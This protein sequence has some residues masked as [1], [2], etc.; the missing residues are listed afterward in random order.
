MTSIEE[1][2][3][4]AV[5][6][7]I[8]EIEHLMQENQELLEENNRLLRKIHR[9]NVWA[10]WLRILWLAVFL[11]IPVIAYYYLVAPYYQSLDTAFQYF[12]IELPDIPTWG[13]GE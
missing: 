5:H 9:S 8:E 6:E 12:G 10:F 7:E 11:G 2:A 1:T 13:D 4:D 3:A